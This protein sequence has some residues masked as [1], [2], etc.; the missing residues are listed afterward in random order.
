M[1][2]TYHVQAAA[3]ILAKD[4]VRIRNQV[5]QYYAMSSQL[6]ALSM[7]MSTMQ[8]YEVI[9]NSLK[10]SSQVL[11]QMNEQMDIQ[12]I[13]Q[14]LKEFNKE[15]MKSEMKQDAM[16]DA[17]DMAMGS[18]DVDEQ[19]QDVYE[20]ILGEIGLEYM[21]AD[22]TKIRQKV[23]QKQQEQEEVKNNNVDDLESRLAALKM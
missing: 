9:A 3:K 5:T 1:I 4:I 10:G 16:N 2:L 21:E 19:A 17:M 23:A 20:G 18:A 15:T 12:Q 22:P 8:S 6:K 11:A 7:K 14:V 13:Q